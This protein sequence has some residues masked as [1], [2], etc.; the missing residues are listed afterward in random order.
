MKTNT[1]SRK[2][3]IYRTAARLFKEKGYSAVTM[4]DLAAAVGIKAASLY[5][6]IS[7]KQQI[8]SE[9]IIDIAEQFTEGI[10]TITHQ[11]TDAVTKLK[12]VITQHITLTAD[13]PYG[14]AALNNDWMHLEGKL[15]YYLNLRSQ[16]ENT[17]KAIVQEGKDSGELKDVNVEILLYSILTTLRN[18]YLWIPKKGELKKDELIKGLTVTLL[19]GVEK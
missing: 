14:M 19:Q 2:Q 1:L 8:L 16:Y 13:N 18:L 3:E 15:D 12:A 7:S 9:I 6:H 5:N 11:K 4:R 10:D 17:F